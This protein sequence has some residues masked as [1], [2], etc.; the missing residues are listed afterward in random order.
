MIKRV[1][2]LITHYTQWIL[3]KNIPYLLIYYVNFAVLTTNSPTLF[4]FI[5]RNFINALI[6]IKYLSSLFL[7]SNKKSTRKNYY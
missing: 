3:F 4:W 2:N 1:F 7:L 5:T 6:L